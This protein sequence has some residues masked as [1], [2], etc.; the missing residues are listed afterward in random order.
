MT[1]VPK[2]RGV[3][4]KGE[5]PK[6]DQMLFAAETAAVDVEKPPSV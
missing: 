3:V 5:G 2:G 1:A 4:D 6:M